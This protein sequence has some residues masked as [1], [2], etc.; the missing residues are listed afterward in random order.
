[1]AI[2][3]SMIY[4]WEMTYHMTGA[5]HGCHRQ[6]PRGFRLTRLLTTDGPVTPLVSKILRLPTP[7]QT[8]DPEFVGASVAL[9]VICSEVN[10]DSDPPLTKANVN[11]NVSTFNGVG[12]LTL[13]RVTHQR[14]AGWGP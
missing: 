9:P 14:R 8:F 12:Y 13:P 6:Q 10:Q 2:S 4:G 1:M 11:V 7:F 3:Q 5:I